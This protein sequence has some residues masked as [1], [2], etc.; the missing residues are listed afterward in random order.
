ML[1]PVENLKHKV[2]VVTG[3][4][5]GIGNATARLLASQGMHVVTVARSKNILASQAEALQKEYNVTVLPVAADLSTE[6]GVQMVYQAALQ[7]FR[8]VD[9]LINNVGVGKYG[10]LNDIS[11]ADYDWILNTN[12]RSSFLCT[13]TFLPDMK[14][15]KQGWVI[16]VGSVAGLRGLPHETVYCASKFAQ[17]GFAQALDFEVRKLGIKVSYIAPGGVHTEF[18]IGTGRNHSDPIVQNMM[19]GEDV[20]ETILFTLRQTDK[21]RLFLLGVRPLQ[22]TL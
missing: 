19:D 15:N 8:F 10:S 4:S 5:K 6:E 18:A 1:L 17:Y 3:A 22:E 12:M 9:V 20:A 11:V 7:R 21:A 2:A 14:K 16:F 13:K